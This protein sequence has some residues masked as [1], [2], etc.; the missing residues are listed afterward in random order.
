MSPAS[1]QADQ[2]FMSNFSAHAGGA[3]RAGG[4]ARAAGSSGRV[5]LA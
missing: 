3:A 4:I 1:V 5:A 2:Q